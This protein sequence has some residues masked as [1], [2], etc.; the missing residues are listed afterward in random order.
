MLKKYFTTSVLAISLV[1]ATAC[2]SPA[3]IIVD[4]HLTSTTQFRTAA[5]NPFFTGFNEYQID[6][7]GVNFTY[8]AGIVASGSKLLGVGIDNINLSTT[9]SV[10]PVP[11]GPFTLVENGGVPSP[12]L[13][14]DFPWTGTENTPR[15][16]GVSVTGTDAT[17]V[18]AIGSQVFF[19]R[20]ADHNSANMIF[21]G[22]SPDT[23]VYV[24]AIG[25]NFGGGATYSVSANGSSI[26]NWTSAPSSGPFGSLFAF[27]TVTDSDGKLSVN[28]LV[29][30][31]VGSYGGFAGILISEQYVVPP[32]PEPASG[33]LLGLGAIVIARRMRR[34]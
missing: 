32:A 33:V 5:Q 21:E 9:G 4:A 22:L 23:R 17:V 1:A 11:T 10:L 20:N 14:L 31:G 15:G 7:V 3:A 6:V 27:D 19:F 8:G 18:N 29:N 2:V 25:S 13:T 24:Q 16:G 34:R 12:T 28:F 26:G 30:T